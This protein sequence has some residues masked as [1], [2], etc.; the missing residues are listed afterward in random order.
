MK[1]FVDY[2]IEFAHMYGGS[3]QDGRLT[4]EQEESA[5]IAC[6]FAEKLRRDGFSCSLCVLIDDYNEP[7]EVDEASV[8]ELLSGCGAPPD[9]ILRES[10]F[11]RQHAAAL[12]DA[13]DS[14][15][16]QES[17]DGELMFDARTDDIRLWAPLP[18][19]KSFREMLRDPFGDLVPPR[20]S[21]SFR[22]SL[23]EKQSHRQTLSVRSTTEAMSVGEQRYSRSTYQ[24]RTEI[25]LSRK[26]DDGNETYACPLLAACWH[27][28]RLG[29]EP[30]EQAAGSAVSFSDRPFF[31]KRLVTILPAA[32][33]KIEATAFEIISSVKL[34][35]VRKQRYKLSYHFF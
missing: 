22:L 1:S 31:A 27:L 33:L 19:S 16:L 4:P 23:L 28:A 8:H 5:R 35:S 13:I 25:V 11:A 6:D 20:K 24:S 29:I 21:T 26:N 17:K 15:Y 2:S 10:Q 14:R 9:H 34:R 7:M 32:Y 12:I 3:L 30:Y 18:D